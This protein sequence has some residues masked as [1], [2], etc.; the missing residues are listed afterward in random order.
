MYS[1]VWPKKMEIYENRK[2]Q[3]VFQANSDG[4][5]L[6]T[7]AVILEYDED[8]NAYSYETIVPDKA[9]T[10]EVV[11]DEETKSIGF[12]SDNFTEN[13]IWSGNEFERIVIKK[14]E[15]KD[16]GVDHFISFS[17]ESIMDGEKITSKYESEHTFDVR[18][19]D[20]ILFSQ[21]N[22]DGDIRKFIPSEGLKQIGDNRFHLEV[23]EKGPLDV[24]FRTYSSEWMIYYFNVVD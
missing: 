11:V 21:K 7:E 1:V 20:T 13:Y 18:L 14:D 24:H 5:G 12:E 8:Y 4:S 16:V 23:T 6:Y 15:L 3:V 19:G 22:I 9:I 10:G 17:I 2:E